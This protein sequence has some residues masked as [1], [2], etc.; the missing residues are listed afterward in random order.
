M[1]LETTFVLVRTNK[2][3]GGGDDDY[4]VCDGEKVI[5]RIVRHLQAPKKA[6]CF[7]AIIAEGRKRSLS[8]RGYAVSRE[9]AM[10]RNFGRN[11]PATTLFVIASSAFQTHR[12][13]RLSLVAFGATS[14]FGSP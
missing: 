14:K 4:D 6:P 11:G 9:Q 12:C 1:D 3:R 7:W 5:G 13:P 8:D 2:S 10:A